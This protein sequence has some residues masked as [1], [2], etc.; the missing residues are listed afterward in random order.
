L[1]SIS[2]SKN[3]SQDTN[4]AE[5]LKKAAETIEKRINYLMEPLKIIELDSTT[6]A[7]QLRSEKPEMND[8]RLSYYE[9]VLKAGKWFGYRNHVSMHRYSQH[10]QDEPNRHAVPFPITK[11]QFQKLIDDLTEIL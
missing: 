2:V 9:L 8:G 3:I 6:K 7:V 11:K 5:Y 10:S 1:N 4:M